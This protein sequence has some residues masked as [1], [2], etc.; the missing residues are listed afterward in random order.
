MPPELP[1]HCLWCRALLMGGATVHR[2][3]C[4]IV[5]LQQ[6]LGLELNLPPHLQVEIEQA[7]IAGISPIASVRVRLDGPSADCTCRTCGHRA[8]SHIGG[9]C[10]EC[11]REACWS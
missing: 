3:D 4:F 6:R 8:V 9:S 5:R 10:F 1:T 7:P 2:P 11:G